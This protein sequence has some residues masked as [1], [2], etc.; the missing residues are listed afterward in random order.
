M[1]Y[2]FKR[3]EENELR[4]KIDKGKVTEVTLYYK[5]KKGL[6]TGIEELKKR[7]LYHPCDVAGALR[8]VPE[9]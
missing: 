8:Q 3:A 7:E 1:K 4:M 2:N 5:D 9:A 6:D